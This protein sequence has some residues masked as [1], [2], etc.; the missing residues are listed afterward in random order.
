MKELIDFIKSKNIEKTHFYTQLK[1][2]KEEA[3]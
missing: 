3:I 1:C 2:T